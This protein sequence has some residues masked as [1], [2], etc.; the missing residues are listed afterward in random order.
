MREEMLESIYNSKRNVLVS[1]SMSVGKTT[2]IGYGI[3]DKIIENDDNMFKLDSRCE[4]LKAYYDVLKDKNYDIKI[5]NMSNFSKSVCYNIFKYCYDL[6]KNG[7]K[8]EALKELDIICKNIFVYDGN[9]DD[10]WVNSAR[11]LF[12]GIVL[13]LFDDAKEDEINFSSIYSIISDCVGDVDYVAEY[14]RTKDMNDIS[15]ICA[16]ASVFSPI[17]TKGGIVATAKEILKPFI[18]KPMLNS[19]LSKTDF[20][21]KDLVNK[22]SAI[23]LISDEVDNELSSLSSIII[24]QIYSILLKENK[25]TCYNFVLDNFD[26]INNI[27]NFRG[28]LSSSIYNNVKFYIF[29]R[30]KKRMESKYLSYLKKICDYIF[31]KEENIVINNSNFEYENKFEVIDIKNS[32]IVYP[33]MK[34]GVTQIFNLKKFIIDNIKI[35]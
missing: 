29:T 24:S 8:D 11:D 17:E 5:I 9:G 15:Y 1:G 19:L 2:N 12:S 20:D 18:N 13:A 32:N 23:F 30:D 3:V 25:N 28:M 7:D 22:K 4:Y 16:S 10:F 33:S 21:I 31:V 6:Y 14:F 34:K 26:T 35:D 27:A